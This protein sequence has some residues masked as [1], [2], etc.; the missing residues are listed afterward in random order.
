[1][2]FSIVKDCGY[3][4]YVYYNG[5]VIINK[6][7]DKDLYIC[8][9]CDWFVENIFV[10]NSWYLVVIILYILLR[11]FNFKVKMS[12]EINFRDC[13]KVSLSNF[14]FSKKFLFEF[15]FLFR[16]W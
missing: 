13:R 4:F 10:F 2:L 3:F 6:G 7:W 11:V 9:F 12:E 1:M 16:V 14:F 15:L 8:E 5:L